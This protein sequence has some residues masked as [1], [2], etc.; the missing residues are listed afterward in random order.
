M[1]WYLCAY[2]CAY[3]YV[4]G[5]NQPLRCYPHCRN[6]SPL[7]SNSALFSALDHNFRSARQLPFE[8]T[9]LGDSAQVRPMV[10]AAWAVKEGDAA[11]SWDVV[12][13]SYLRVKTNDRAITCK[14]IEK[15]AKNDWNCS[16]WSLRVPFQRSSPLNP[17]ITTKRYFPHYALSAAGVH[18][19]ESHLHHW[20]KGRVVRVVSFFN[21]VPDCLKCYTIAPSASESYSGLFQEKV[22]N[23]WQQRGGS[24]ETKTAHI[25]SATW[26]AQPYNAKKPTWRN[27]T[28]VRIFPVSRKRV[29]NLALQLT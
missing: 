20:Y 13:W 2:A 15:M 17:I 10:Q 24:Q 3:A 7:P 25:I 26:L 4:A 9:L 28:W 22:G 27:P 8:A 23:V 16:F 1:S 5:E 14:S 21:G 11:N 29:C 18:K 19:I 12:T 6:Y